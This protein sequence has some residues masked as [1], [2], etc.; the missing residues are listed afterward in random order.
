MKTMLNKV[1]EEGQKLQLMDGSEWLINP[2]DIPTSL[3][4]LPADHI[5]TRKQKNRDMF[6]HKL[7]NL[8]NDQFVYGMKLK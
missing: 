5:E 4:W 1:L 2:G 7:T 8:Y 3:L 6:D